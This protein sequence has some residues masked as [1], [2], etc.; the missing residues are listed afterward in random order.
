MALKRH[1]TIEVAL[2]D[3]SVWHFQRD[4][5]IFSLC[6][7]LVSRPRY[8]LQASFTSTAHPSGTAEQSSAA[9]RSSG[10]VHRYLPVSCII[11]H[12][13]RSQ[14][15]ES[16]E[17]KRWTRNATP[18]VLCRVKNNSRTRAKK[19]QPLSYFFFSLLLYFSSGLHPVNF[20]IGARPMSP[21]GR[22]QDGN[23]PRTALHEGPRSKPCTLL[24]AMFNI[25]VRPLIQ[26][27][28][29]NT[30]QPQKNNLR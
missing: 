14:G 20:L 3:G 30:K 23:K 5:D 19:G 12:W 13:G 21:A 2:S 15:R 28:A 24:F 27:W 6:I 16:R 1:I 4:L 11:W 8:F 9:F 25:Q 26:Q 29:S 18:G 22:P 17:Q 7:T 10:V